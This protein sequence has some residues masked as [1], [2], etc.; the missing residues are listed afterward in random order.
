MMTIGGDFNAKDISWG[1]RKSNPSGKK[2]LKWAAE[3]LFNVIAPDDITHIVSNDR[4]RNDILDIFITTID[5]PVIQCQV[6][7][8]LTSDHLP[9]E[10]EL[11]FK[12]QDM[13]A[14]NVRIPN[15]ERYA[16]LMEG[17]T[18]DILFKEN[19]NN[20]NYID[21]AI[22][23]LDEAVKL[24]YYNCLK[25]KKVLKPEHVCLP[26]EILFKIRTR[27]RARK[28]YQK[29]GKRTYLN[30]F[31][32]LKS[33]IKQS[34]KKIKNV[35]VERDILDL[36]LADG[37][38]SN[39]NLW[40]AVKRLKRNNLTTNVPF[41]LNDR[42]VAMTDSDKCRAFADHLKLLFTP[43]MSAQE[44]NNPT[45][46][47]NNDE[48]NNLP[49]RTRED[50]EG[51]SERNDGRFVNVNNRIPNSGGRSVER[52][53]PTSESEIHESIQAYALSSS[54]D[55]IKA[56]DDEVLKGL[57]NGKKPGHDAI[58]TKMIKYFPKVTVFLLSRIFN[59]CM[60]IGYFPSAWKY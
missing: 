36:D 35:R 45:D 57:K 18:T 25:L 52:G 24:A 9:V 41:I 29:T 21:H 7:N 46:Y 58:S 12:L 51:D 16:K 20:E 59:A 48:V 23:K 38:E 40:R 27:N 15:W 56:K 42:E 43:M 8:E 19:L 53:G 11:N 31:K 30:L 22:G 54:D 10:L 17:K 44:A 1:C 14:G 60:W 49:N 3:C 28:M 6:L 39:Q 26:E 50:T 13:L 2:L 33:D 32:C 37:D 5:L 34:I 4:R 55:I 47:I